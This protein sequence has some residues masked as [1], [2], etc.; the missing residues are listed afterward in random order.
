M[1]TMTLT[2]D[3]TPRHSGDPIFLGVCSE[4]ARTLHIPAGQVRLIAVATIVS[5]LVIPG[6]IAYAIL[7]QSLRA[8]RRFHQN[9]Q[10]CAR[11]ARAGRPLDA[12]MATPRA[13]P[14]RAEKL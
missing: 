8:R 3:T 6:L 11:I 4:I 1:T 2:A 7:G 14:D 5:S 12:Y 9:T 10:Q 13:V